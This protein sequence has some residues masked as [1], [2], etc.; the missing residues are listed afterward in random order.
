MA[1]LIDSMPADAVASIRDTFN[2]AVK[3]MQ[4][5]SKPSGPRPKIKPDVI[6]DDGFDPVNDIEYSY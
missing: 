3:M 4:P 6:V 5:P 1:S 2:F